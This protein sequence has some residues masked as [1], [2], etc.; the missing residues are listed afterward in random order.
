MGA[1]QR[2]CAGRNCL[3]L[4]AIGGVRGVV[5]WSA[6]GD[7]RHRALGAGCVVWGRWRRSVTIAAWSRSGV[8]WVVPV[9]SSA[10][11][12]I[13]TALGWSGRWVRV[14]LRGSGFCL[15][16]HRTGVARM[17][18]ITDHRPPNAFA[19]PARA[20]PVVVEP[21]DEAV[22]GLLRLRH[23]A[24]GSDPVAALRG[25]WAG[26]G[27]FWAPYWSPKR[28]GP[29]RPARL[30]V[31]FDV[32]VTF[33]PTRT[34]SNLRRRGP[35]GGGGPVERG[36]IAPNRPTRLQALPT[37]D[38]GPLSASASRQTGPPSR[39]RH[40][41][42]E[43][44]APAPAD[45]EPTPS[46]TDP[47]HSPRCRQTTPALRPTSER[48]AQADAPPKRSQHTRPAPRPR[49]TTTVSGGPLPVPARRSGRPSC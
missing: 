25:V 22:A 10:R 23:F 40:G 42:R 33:K 18:H 27:S 30:R 37:T 16:G 36:C 12:T 3:V 47:A 49:P 4:W 7:D 45:D 35:C 48:N 9:G 13:S 34:G 20:A 38:V 14:L 31:V 24:A 2:G 26:S 46:T 44:P 17:S 5:G 1:R 21:C 41:Q 43:S 8:R 29:P 15:C 6:L 39:G 28:P 19:L 32:H 11:S